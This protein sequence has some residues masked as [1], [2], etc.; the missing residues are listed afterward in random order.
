M[1]G[2][3]LGTVS[4]TPTGRPQQ[5]GSRGAPQSLRIKGI[6]RERGSRRTARAGLPPRASLTW[7]GGLGGGRGLRDWAPASGGV[8]GGAAPESPGLAGKHR[9]TASAGQGARSRAEAPAMP[10]RSGRDKTPAAGASGQSRGRR[11]RKRPQ[12]ARGNRGR[13]GSLHKSIKRLEIRLARGYSLGRGR[14]N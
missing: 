14:L 8:A 4:R 1:K 3:K 11:L 7:G 6:Q 5:P 9:D 10:R 2:D 12:A 13:R